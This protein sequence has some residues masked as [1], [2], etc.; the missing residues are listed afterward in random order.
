M[1]S[2]VRCCVWTGRLYA[3]LFLVECIGSAAF[4]SWGP[5]EA[6]ACL[7]FTAAISYGLFTAVESRRAGAP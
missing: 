1:V 7:P 3:V 2:Y 6:S 4:H 5:L